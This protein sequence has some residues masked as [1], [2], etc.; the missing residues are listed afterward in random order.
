MKVINILF[1]YNRF[2]RKSD[3]YDLLVFIKPQNNLFVR[4][5][6]A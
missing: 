6:F 4:K 5:Q 2:L 3:K 1:H